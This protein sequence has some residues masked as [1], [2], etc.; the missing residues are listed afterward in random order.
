MNEFLSLYGA[1]NTNT[2]I[3][4]RLL[5]S[6]FSCSAA[7]LTTLILRLF[8]MPLALCSLWLFYTNIGDDSHGLFSKN[9]LILN[10]L[11]L[12]LGSSILTTI[13]ICR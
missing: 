3:F 1:A 4:R 7:G 10:I 8:T 9:G 2:D 13:S 5:A 11:G 6:T 12:T